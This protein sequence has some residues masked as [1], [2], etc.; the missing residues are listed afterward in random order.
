[1]SDMTPKDLTAKV[2]REI[3][4]EIRKTNDEIRKTNGEVR[5]TNERLDATAAR[6]DDRMTQVE[7]RLG[8]EL[9]AVKASLR[10]VVDLLRDRRDDRDRVERHERWLADLD[11]R[12]RQLESSTPAPR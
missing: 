6:L 10:E 4:D 3:R 1:M 5:K 7:V 9:V 11:G 8:T 12:V 2:L